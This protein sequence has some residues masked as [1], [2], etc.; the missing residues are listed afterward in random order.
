MEQ[1]R[2]IIEDVTVLQQTVSP[3]PHDVN[4]IF[5]TLRWLSLALARKKPVGAHGRSARSTPPA[6]FPYG[7][8]QKEHRAVGTLP[9]GGRCRTPGRGQIASN[10]LNK[11]PGLR[12]RQR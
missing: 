2:M 8:Q 5:A 6:A 10:R 4:T 9:K 12:Y 7:V 1:G 3:A 11:G